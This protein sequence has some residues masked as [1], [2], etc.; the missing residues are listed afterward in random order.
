MLESFAHNLSKA[1][2]KGELC[3]GDWAPDEGA[4]INVNLV[5]TFGPTHL[6]MNDHYP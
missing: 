1:F 4:K 6:S 5:L 3:V 2:V